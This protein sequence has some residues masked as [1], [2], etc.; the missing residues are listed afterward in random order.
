MK[1][2]TVP[3]LLV[4]ATFLCACGNQKSTVNKVNSDAQTMNT[5]AAEAAVPFTPARNYFVRNDYKDTALHLLKLESGEAFDRVFGM[6]ATMGADG[7]PTFVN[8]DTHYVL[9][10]V[11]E[12]SS[13]SVALEAA[14]LTSGNGNILLICSRK[15]GPVQSFI[16]RSSLILLVEKRYQGNPVL[17]LQ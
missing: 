10:C 14:S 2:Q 7:K 5:G 6:A 12:S 9:A 17:Q 4:I 13:K 1:H 3:V 16:S 15:E 8:F 11:S